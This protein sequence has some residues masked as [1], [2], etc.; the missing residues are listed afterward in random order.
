MP[1]TKDSIKLLESERL[2]DTDDGGGRMTGNEVVDGQ[3]NNLFNDISRLDRTVGRVS[4]RKTFVG[5]QTAD[6]SVYAGAHAIVTN[7]PADGGVHVTLFSTQDDDDERNAAKNRIE[8]Y[9]ISGP[10][11][12]MRLYDRHVTGQRTL[13]IFQFPSDRLPEIGE[14]YSLTKGEGTGSEFQQYF[15]ILKLDSQVVVFKNSQF[16]DFS[17]RVLNVEIDSALRDDFPGYTP[18]PRDDLLDSQFNGNE[19]DRPKIRQTAIADASRYFGVVPLAQAVT[20]NDVDILADSIFS[21]VVPSTQAESPILDVDATLDVAQMVQSGDEITVQIRDVTNVEVRPGYPTHRICKFY[22]GGSITPG[23]L[24][25]TLRNGGLWGEIRD[26]GA[27]GAIV[28]VA[29]H[30]AP[31]G[32]PWV[33][34]EQGWV[35][36]AVGYAINDLDVDVK[37]KPATRIAQVSTTKQVEISEQ[38]RQLTYTDFLKPIPAPGTLA[39]SFRS[40]DKWYTLRDDGAG[41][42]IPEID[43]TGG[44]TVNYATGSVAVTVAFEPDVG[45]SVIFQWGTAA[46]YNNRAGEAIAVKPGITIKAAQGHCEPSSVSISWESGG[47]TKTATDDGAGNITGDAT[48]RILYQTGQ[49]YFVPNAYPDPN[50]FISMSYDH[51]VRVTDTFTPTKDG[52]GFISMTAGTTPIKPGSVRVSWSTTRTAQVTEQAANARG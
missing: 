49:V 32:S 45:S 29:G 22:V 9:T 24:V 33:D 46:H 40:L 27:G 3:V 21:A 48:G 25:V 31:H 38:N 8:S 52:N 34:Y 26:D 36:V 5:V 7:P 14:V 47:V 41:G 13:Q 18:A 50:V 19:A 2:Q 23:S 30:L 51:G 10:L 12:R 16:G 35:Y 39:V 28:T 1:I 6:N 44:G 43:G 11:S 15:R 42:L 17:V 4:L 37:F 20:A